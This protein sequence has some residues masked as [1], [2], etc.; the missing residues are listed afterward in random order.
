MNT[1]SLVANAVEKVEEAAKKGQRYSE[2]WCVFD[3]DSFPLENYARAFQLAESNKIK[4][5]WA[6]E[7]FELWYLLHYCY[8]DAPVGRA[9]YDSGERRAE[10]KNPST[11]LHKLV[12][13]LNELASL[14]SANCPA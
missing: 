9:D 7:A 5:A 3:R 8:L 11:G 4:L 2:V 14:G 10:R 12:D 13:Y 1:D 6:N